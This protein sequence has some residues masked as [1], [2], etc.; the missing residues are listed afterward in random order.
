M[1]RTTSETPDD[2][3]MAASCSSTNLGHRMQEP[4]DQGSPPRPRHAPAVRPGPSR[5]THVDPDEPAGIAPTD[6]VVGLTRAGAAALLCVSSSTVRRLE[7]RGVLHPRIVDGIHFFDPAEIH[8]ARAERASGAPTDG[9][10]AALAFELLDQGAGL[11]EVVK[12]CRVPPER[13]R[14]L[15]IDWKKMGSGELVISAEIRAEISRVLGVR[16]LSSDALL[17]AVRDIVLERDRLEREFA[18]MQEERNAAED[19]LGSEQLRELYAARERARS[20]AAADPPGDSTSRSAT[21]R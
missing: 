10:A 1:R 18:E 6:K 14:A 5:A 9:E 12:R 11:R 15:A 3:V 8:R 4:G 7:E 20:S 2:R 17:R 16:I 21:T 19:L 13:A